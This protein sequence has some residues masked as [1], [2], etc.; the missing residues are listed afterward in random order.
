MLEIPGGNTYADRARANSKPA[1]KFMP[2]PLFEN[3]PNDLVAAHIRYNM[4]RNLMFR[5]RHG[6]ENQL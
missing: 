4:D 5:A 2:S 1:T 6:E 3:P